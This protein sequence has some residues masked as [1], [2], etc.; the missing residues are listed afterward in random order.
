M[1]PAS[2]LAFAAGLTCALNATKGS[3]SA[4]IAEQCIPGKFGSVG[5]VPDLAHNEK[6]APVAT[7]DE[8]RQ[9]FSYGLFIVIEGGAVY[10]PVAFSYGPPGRKASIV[11][12]CF[13]GPVS[14]A[15]T[16]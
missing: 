12:V 11:N 8:L 13:E 2:E 3:Q 4:G 15:Y 1:K 6:L 9:A 7:A 10:V 16:Q 5:I 14:L